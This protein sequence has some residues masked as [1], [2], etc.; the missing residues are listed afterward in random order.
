VPAPKAEQAEA[1]A[2]PV[3]KAVPEI[4]PQAEAPAVAERTPVVPT[5]Q[6]QRVTVPAGTLI[7]IRMIDSV[8][9]RTDQVGQTFRASID[10]DITIQDQIVVPKGADA[11]LTLTLVTS[12]G[13]FRGK[14]QL[15]LELDRIA[16]GE[17]SYVVKSDVV[18]R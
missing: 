2:A 14:S 17:A 18:E 9:S 10:S 15:Q 8:D 11:R 5:P 4:E 1:K 6:V 16:I 3:V 7:P 13:E 12:A